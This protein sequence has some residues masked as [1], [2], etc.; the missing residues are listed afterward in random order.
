MTQ[1]TCPRGYDHCVPLSMIMADDKSS[2]FCCGENDGS[3]R[4][5]EQDR[6]TKCF[7]SDY[8]DSISDVDKRDLTHEAAVILNVLA[9]IA[10]E[11]NNAR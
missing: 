6:W 5:F 10:D 3:R 8:D 4:Q 9:R 7:H 1:E 11:E 2:F